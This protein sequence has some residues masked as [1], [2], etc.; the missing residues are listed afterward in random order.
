MGRGPL[1]PN[2]D[3]INFDEQLPAINGP[4]PIRQLSGGAAACSSFQHGDPPALLC[5]Q[6]LFPIESP[7]DVKC[8]LQQSM[9]A[10]AMERDNQISLKVGV[11]GFLAGEVL[12]NLEVLPSLSKTCNANFTALDKKP[13]LSIPFPNC[14]C[15]K[16]PRRS[17]LTSPPFATL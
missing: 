16:P 6:L 10:E 13:L 8:P 12:G 2:A 17:A 5:G 4:S 15:R 11:I 3:T 7:D 9:I 1:F 14:L